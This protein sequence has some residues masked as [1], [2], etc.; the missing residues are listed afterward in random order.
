MRDYAIQLAL[1]RPDPAQRLNILREYVQACVLR[2]LHE[3][4]AFSSLAFV[5]GTALRFLYELPRFSEDLDFSQTGE[6]P[7]QAVAWMRKVKGDLEKAGF[8]PRVTWN[9]RK[10]VQSGWVRVAGLLKDIGLSG[11]AEEA[12]SIKVEIDTNPPPGGC[13]AQ[14]VLTRHLTF[15]VRHHTLPCLMAGKIHALLTR[16]YTKG[17]DW[18]DL[19]W[20]LSQQPPVLPEQAFLQEA[21]DQTQ[22]KG[23]VASAAWPTLVCERL[24]RADAGGI[25]EDV[26]PFLE[27]PADAQ[28][29]TPDYLM[30]LLKAVVLS[31]RS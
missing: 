7:A 27:R 19:F 9:D 31:G 26:R 1:A 3:A 2:S 23:R 29:L 13:C 17:R 21:L 12:L 10:T 28:Y 15:F 25:I 18:Y 20:Y 8:A 5:G 16:K 24:S 22:G 4:E 6:H 30:P 14:R 11:Q